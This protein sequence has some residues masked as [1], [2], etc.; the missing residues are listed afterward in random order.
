MSLQNQRT[1]ALV[2]HG[3][4]GKTSVAEMLLFQT[5]IINRLGKIEEGTTSLDTEPEEIK[6]RG[7]IQPAFASYDWKKNT[8]FLID[9]PGDNNFVGD[10]SYCLAGTDA[11]VFTIDAVDGAK[12]LTKR[13]WEQVK[14]VGRPAMVFINKMDRDRA[15]FQM[16]FDSLHSILG[17]RPV[18][19]YMPIGAKEDFR[20]VVDV[21]GNKALLFDADGK[22]I[23][24]EIPGDMA[25]EVEILRETMIENIAES[26]EELM[27]KYLEEGE[28]SAEDI[29]HG[30]RLGVLA[31]EL[32]PVACGAALQNAGAQQILD[33]AQ[34]LFPAP[35]ESGPW[36]GEGEGD[37]LTADPDGPLVT[38]VFK[39][40]SDPFAGQLTVLRVLSGT[41]KPDCTLL[42][43]SK[44]EKERVGQLLNMV[45]KEQKPMKAPAGPG[46]IVALAKLKSTHT[47][48][49]LCAEKGS[50][51]FPKPK[52]APALISYALAPEEKG[53][54]DKVYTAVHKILEE[55]VCLN[56]H[57][58]AETGDILLSGSGQLH[59]EI[60]VEK[61]KRRYKTGIL[62]K[63]PKIPYRETFKAKADVQG[64][65]KKQSGGRGQFGDC[66]IRL[67]PQP[68]GAGY[69]FVD[70]IVGGS[71]PRQYIPA[72]DKGVQEAAAR[73]VIAGY[74]VV[75][76]KVSCYDGSYHS[77]DSS[78]MAFKVAGS[79]AFKK[80]AEVAKPVLLEPVVQVSVFVPDEF[81]GDVI[82][83]L[84][85]R[86]GKV[87]GSDSQSGL[88][89]VKAHVPMAEVL[90][91][92]P[93]LRS[94]T[95]GQGTFTME[96][97]HYEEAPPNVTEQVIAESKKE[98]H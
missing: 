44:E 96:F 53:E 25:D 30:M 34:D 4:V 39:T 70:E 37:E 57:R 21:L 71:I 13:L 93:D 59:I 2:G 29:A 17:I 56:L 66:F 10:L 91:Y 36:Q 94:M 32:V 67:E 22:T 16:A 90:Q 69:E 52:L 86:R 7:S 65:H 98:E 92:A 26:D 72:V 89:E 95:G 35:T 51:V 87:L 33:I 64:R 11:V 18:L 9:T 14:A 31:G 84:S 24:G 46:S 8:H 19:L 81:M 82:G 12:P 75:D 97:D 55:D 68:R 85:S 27:E 28:L 79:V 76:Y 77:V 15:D 88:T 47:G 1:Y 20:G 60:S 74:P 50:F 54:E 38:F 6:R 48:D 62:L 5:G 73:G 40:I 45:G 61:A 83:D 63:T 49:T 3:G 41:L 23:E 43:T 80:A 78:E 58:D 42:N